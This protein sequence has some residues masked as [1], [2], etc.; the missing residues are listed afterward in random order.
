[1]SDLERETDC[2]D[3]LKDYP[4]IP[5]ASVDAAIRSLMNLLRFS[6]S[7]VALLGHGLAVTLALK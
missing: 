3:F 2:S 6:E 5:F 4:Q 1:M 7:K